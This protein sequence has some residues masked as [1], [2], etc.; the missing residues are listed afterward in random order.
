MSGRFVTFEGGEGSGKST[1][2]QRLAARLREAGEDLVLVREPGGTPLAERIRALLLDPGFAPDPM[3]EVYLMEAARADLVVSVIRPALTAGRTVLCDRFA[4]STLAYQGG[5]R[6]IDCDLLVTFNDA[7][8]GGLIPDLTL[9]FDLDP[10]I[11]LARR[12]AHGAT[13][14]LDREPLA[15]HERVRAEYLRLAAAE[16]G[17]VLVID[18]SLAPEALEARTWACYRKAQPVR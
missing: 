17:R 1:Q 2:L 11:G 9:L 5:G 14:R 13:N 6:G 8:T 10:R 3:A 7:A 15:F 16:P 4:D 18:A 12:D